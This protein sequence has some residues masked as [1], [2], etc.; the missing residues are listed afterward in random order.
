MPVLGHPAA[1]GS[2]SLRVME[3]AAAGAVRALWNLSFNKQNLA[4]MKGQWYSVSER[5]TCEWALGVVS[6]E[7]V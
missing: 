1:C 2:G 3:A 6:S 7:R 5:L 4:A